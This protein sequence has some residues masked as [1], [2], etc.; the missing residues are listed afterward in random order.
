MVEIKI[1]T[2]TMQEA[3]A[4]MSKFK[5]PAETVTEKPIEITTVEV[6]EVETSEEKVTEETKY[7]LAEVRG[8]LAALTKAGKRQQVHD[9]IRSFGVTKLPEIPEDKYAEVMQKAGEI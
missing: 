9:L 4:E 8:T 1:I 7:S 2:D 6:P 5:E 3:L